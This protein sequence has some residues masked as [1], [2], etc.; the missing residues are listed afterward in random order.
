MLHGGYILSF[1]KW[2]VHNTSPSSSFRV[3]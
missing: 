2:N 1:D 3:V